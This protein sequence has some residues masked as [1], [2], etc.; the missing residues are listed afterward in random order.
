LLVK[1]VKIKI[2]EV[3]FISQLHIEAKF[4]NSN[5]PL[6]ADNYANC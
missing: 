3:T 1:T 4:P 5:F 6:K 2:G